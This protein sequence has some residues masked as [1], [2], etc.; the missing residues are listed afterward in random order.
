MDDLSGITS[1]THFSDLGLCP[2]ITTDPLW[3]AKYL[4]GIDFTLLAID[5]LQDPVLNSSMHLVS[6]NCGTY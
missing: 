4:R 1:E 3:Q 6:P 5:E 2:N